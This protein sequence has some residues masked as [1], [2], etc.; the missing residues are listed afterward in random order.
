MKNLEK[1][2]N[3]TSVREFTGEIMNDKDVELIRRVINNSPTSTNQQQFS[4][5][6]IRDKEMLDWI[7]TNNWNQQHI[8]DA[9]AFIVFV[10]DR[11][12]V[13]YVSNQEK[14]KPTT[15]MLKH[16]FL[17]SVVD[18]TIACTYSMN[19][20]IEMGYGTTM[21]GG[22]VNFA[23]ELS[24]KLSLPSESM[25]VVGLSIGKIKRE[26]PVKEKMNKV[27]LEKYDSKISIQNLID[28]EESTNQIF[29]ERKITKYRDGIRTWQNGDKPISEKAGDYIKDKF[30]NFK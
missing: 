16:E 17:R 8:K 21:V 15:K 14:I 10:A 12:R 4:A 13:N 7:G 26:N 24:N 11:H 3:R 23:D 5:I 6:I 9:S 30:D 27:F 2:I 1:F 19:A 28:Y 25:I 29:S 22:V 18:A 20:L